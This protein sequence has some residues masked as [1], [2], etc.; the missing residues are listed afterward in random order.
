M[1]LL[2]VY[3]ESTMTIRTCVVGTLLFVQ[4]PEIIPTHVSE[5][6]ILRK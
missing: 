5:R 2:L 4:I 1:T 3:T 6:M